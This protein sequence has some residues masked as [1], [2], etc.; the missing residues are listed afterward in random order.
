MR[1]NDITLHIMSDNTFNIKKVLGIDSTK[2][3]IRKDQTK[4]I[5]DETVRRQVTP[6]KSLGQCGTLAFDT[7]GSIFSSKSFTKKNENDF[8]AIGNVFAKRIAQNA[9][10]KPCHFCECEGHNT[11]TAYMTCI[12]CEHQGSLS[13]DYVRSFPSSY[14]FD[15]N[16]IHFQE[17]ALET[18]DGDSYEDNEF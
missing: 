2:A 8:K 17:D 15:F 7:D 11:G 12:S 4:L 5:G 18:A 10:P 13:T 3:Y 6:I 1:E 14:G 9:R 16:L